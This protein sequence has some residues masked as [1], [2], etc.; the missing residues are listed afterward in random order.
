MERGVGERAQSGRRRQVFQSSAAGVGGKVPAWTLGS[1]PRVTKGEMLL[2][3]ALYDAPF[4]AF[5]DTSPASQGRILC[6][7]RH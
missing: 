6:R 7:W 5:G 1:S 4:V 3:L 2:P